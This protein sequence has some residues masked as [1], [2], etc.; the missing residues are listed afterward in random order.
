M[1]WH[2]EGSNDRVNWILLDRRIYLSESTVY[3]KQVEAE[4]H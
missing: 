2:F 1:N 4:Q 3:N